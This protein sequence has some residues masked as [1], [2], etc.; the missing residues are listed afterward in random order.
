MPSRAPV[1][2]AAHG[3]APPFRVHFILC[4]NVG[5]PCA[6][7]CVRSFARLEEAERFAAD[8]LGRSPAPAD[9][10]TERLAEVRCLRG[11]A[12]V[13]IRRIGWRGDATPA[14][15]AGARA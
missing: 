13:V 2:T 8:V 15:D 9:P 14:A 7:G 1:R 5:S 10:R 12:E 6:S 11:G 3:A 4:P